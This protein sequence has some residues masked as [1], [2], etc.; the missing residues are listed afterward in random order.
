MVQI[1]QWVNWENYEICLIS[2]LQWEALDISSRK[3]RLWHRN[4]WILPDLTMTKIYDSQFLEFMC[5][6]YIYLQMSSFYRYNL[7]FL[8]FMSCLQYCKFKKDKYLVLAK[9]HFTKHK[10]CFLALGCLLKWL[11]PAVSPGVGAYM[12]IA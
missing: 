7:W 3:L 11:P 10:Y 2:V 1:K 6:A 8:T 5:F 12:A 4:T 9:N